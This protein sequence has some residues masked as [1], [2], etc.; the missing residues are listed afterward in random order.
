MPIL[1]ITIDK[2]L[3]DFL[4]FAMPKG[5]LTICKNLIPLD[6]NK[7]IFMPNQIAYSSNALTGVPVSAQEFYAD[8]SIYYAFIGTKTGIWRIG[9]GNN[10]V[11]VTRISAPYTTN[12]NR[13]S[14]AKYGNWVIATNFDDEIQVIK[15]M[16]ASN[17][18]PLVIN[19]TIK[20][21]YC[22]QNHG[23]LL[24]GYVIKNGITYPNGVLISKK[25]NI[26]DFSSIPGTDLVNLEECT[27]AITGMVIFEFASAGYDSNMAI[28]HKNSISVAWYTGSPFD[29]NFDYNRY[30][31]I[32][33]LPGTPI[34]VDGICYF[35]DEKTFY[36][37]D[38][39]NKPEDIGFGIRE[40]IL[41]Q[42]DISS[43][44]RINPASHPRMGL[45]VWSF[46][47][48]NGNGIP[49]FLL[50]L[51]VRNGKF[52]LVKT[53]QHCIFTL[54]RNAW[55]ID[56]MGDF[57]P[58]IE[59]IP[60]P[61]NSNYWSDTSSTFACIGTD[62]KVNVFQGNAMDWEIETGE[63]STPEKEII[64]VSRA[65]PMIQKRTGDITVSFGTRMEKT[66]SVD[67]RSSIIRPN[68]YV[69]LRKSG[70]FVRTK[71]TGSTMDGLTGIEVEGEIIGR[72]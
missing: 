56:Q 38:G 21:K 34:L 7:F 52:S 25:D 61:M 54:H 50:I 36:R 28:F 71:M 11:D 65:Y 9:P 59:D 51:N 8:D 44:Y 45:A 32:G 31:E 39:I 27:S 26:G 67:Y 17:F 49:D 41:S 16:T 2:W 24:L 4:P 37:W 60:W 47:S 12:E 66:D 29:F 68:G 30:L 42:L 13:W 46:V 69:D 23:H 18:Q 63:F 35:F 20:A 3:P 58:T 48:N 5:G 15:G 19:E 33:A 64:R 55:T 53:N 10:L 70:R 72:H 40:Y 43:Y 6:D 14:F 62:L 1:D 57:F 22:V